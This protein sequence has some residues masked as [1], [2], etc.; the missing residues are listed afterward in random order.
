MIHFFTVHDPLLFCA[1]SQHHFLFF[2]SLCHFGLPSPVPVLP[3]PTFTLF[4]HVLCVKLLVLKKQLIDK[5]GGNF[6][7]YEAERSVNKLL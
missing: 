3:A 1:V 6:K 2:S 7:H 5:D 4:L